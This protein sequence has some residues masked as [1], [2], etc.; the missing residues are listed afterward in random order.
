[1]KKRELNSLIAELGEAVKPPDARRSRFY[2]AFT[3]AL[4][5]V[6]LEIVEEGGLTR[7]ELVYLLLASVKVV[8][9]GG[10]GKETER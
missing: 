9:V 1:M 6:P 5:E 4:L 2:R 3:E 8:G 10:K 7:E